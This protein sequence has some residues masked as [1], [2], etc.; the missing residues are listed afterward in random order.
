MHTAFDSASTDLGVVGWLLL[1]VCICKSAEVFRE[2]HLLKRKIAWRGLPSSF[3]AGLAPR[4]VQPPCCSLV[5][6]RS[7]A[8]VILRRKFLTRMAS[9]FLRLLQDNM[10]VSSTCAQFLADTPRQ[11]AS[12][13]IYLKPFFY[14]VKLVSWQ[15]SLQE[16]EAV[17]R[18]GVATRGTAL[19]ASRE[20]SRSEPHAFVVSLVHCGS[21]DWFLSLQS[22]DCAW[23]A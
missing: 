23:N 18:T 1:Y 17:S 4:G 11:K 7:S 16:K 5:T 21:D 6:A 14:G 9:F 2:G 13:T 12:V 20:K 22:S 10:H 3:A 8:S 19:S 15:D